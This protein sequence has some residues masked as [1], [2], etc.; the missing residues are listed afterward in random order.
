MAIEPREEKLHSAG[1]YCPYYKFHGRCRFSDNCRHAHHPDELRWYGNKQRRCD[2]EREKWYDEVEHYIYVQGWTLWEGFL[3]SQGFYLNPGE[4]YLPRQCD[5]KTIG[6]FHCFAY[7]WKT[8]Q[9]NESLKKKWHKWVSAA[10][11]ES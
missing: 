5:K 9:S 11:N 8:C 10:L 3:K 1:K 7:P 2:P 4:R 6:S